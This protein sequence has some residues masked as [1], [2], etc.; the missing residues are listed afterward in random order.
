MPK[1]SRPIGVPPILASLPEIHRSTPKDFH[2]HT[3][4][5][6]RLDKISLTI[7]QCNSLS[8]RSRELLVCIYMMDKKFLSTPEIS[9]LI[10]KL[11]GGSL[12][13]FRL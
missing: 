1:E 11:R 6:P 13:F 2:Q 10:K 8:I 12:I 3:P 7:K 4:V 9:E 5:I